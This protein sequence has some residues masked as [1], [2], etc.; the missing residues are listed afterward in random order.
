MIS[1][2]RLDINRCRSLRHLPCGIEKLTSLR[3]L[4]QFPVGKERG[5]KISELGDLN[6]LEGK[7]MIQGLKNVGGLSEAKSANL[8]CKTNLSNLWLDWLENY[9]KESY[10]PE[11][12]PYMEEVLEGLEPNPS[13]E[14]LKMRSYMG[15][16]ISPSWMD[17]LRNLVEIG[18]YGCHNCEHIPPLGRL[19]SLRVIHLSSM[20]S[21]KCFHA[22]D[23]NMSADNN[24]M[25]ISLQRLEISWCGELISLPDNLPKL[26]WFDESGP[27]DDDDDDDEDED[28][29]EDDNDDDDEDVDVDED[30]D[31]DDD[32]DDDDD[33]DEDV[34]EDEDEDD[35]EDE[36]GDEDGD[37]EINE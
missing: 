22:D 1:L 14:I 36:D 8:I 17:N 34:D 27:D 10:T 3:M 7:L 33:E 11:M 37:D 28:V 23:I 25:F 18:F 9:T 4:P 20:H 5:A 32:D 13:L 29:D 12:F 2:Q 35:D 15:K 6:L 16:T 24:D 26:E 19:P 21:L 30:E 31:D